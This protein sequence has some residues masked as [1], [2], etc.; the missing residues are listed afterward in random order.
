MESSELRKIWK[1]LAE[2]KLIDRK[3]AKESILE[4][5]TQKGNGV[6]HKI[7]KKHKFDFKG[8]LAAAVLILLFAFFVTYRDRQFPD[9]KTTAEIS[10][11]NIIFG[12]LEAFMIYAMMSLKRN[13]DFI[14]KTYNTGT[15]KESL[16][17]VKSYFKSITKS[18]FWIGSLSLMTILTFILVTTLVKLEGIKNM[19]F[20]FSGSYIYESYFSI[21][22]LILIFSVPF[23][24][25][26]DARKYASVL[27][28]LDQTIDELNEEV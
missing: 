23:I 9:S 20:S 16:L 3:L 28:D 17:N 14:K 1:T 24:V 12:L 4:I 11:Q 25:R 10:N 19:N 6:I 26:K 27:R 2:E 7:L 22:L 15:L 5:I 21:F 8:Y 18:G 13:M